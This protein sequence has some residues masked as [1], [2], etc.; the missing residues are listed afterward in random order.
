MTELTRPRVLPGPPAAR[1]AV[2][3]G[4]YAAQGFGYAVVVSALPTLKEKIGFSEGLL[5]AVLLGVCLA[6][7]LGSMLADVIAVRWGSRWSLAAGFLIEAVALAV[8]IGSRDIELFVAAVLAYGLGLGVVDAA[9]NMQGA[10]AEA[11]TSQPLFGRLYAAY[12]VA[13]VLGALATSVVQASDLPSLSTIGIAAFLGT[14]VACLAVRFSDPHIAP[15]QTSGSTRKVVREKLPRRGIFLTGTLVFIAFVVDAAVSSWSTLYMQDGL[16][17]SPSVAPLAYAAY[18]SVV[19]VGR[20]AADPMVKR[21]GRE[22]TS[23]TGVVLALLGCVLLVVVHSPT[24]AIIGFALTGGAAGLLVPVAFSWAG[25]LLPRRSDEVIARVNLF[26]YGGAIVGAAALGALA[27]NAA[28]LGIGFLLP[29][30]ALVLSLPVL[31]AIRQ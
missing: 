18:L 31:R 4:T 25:E 17:S 21:W 16:E 9:C 19:L 5:S 14:L 22:L 1:L 29:S 11:T 6:A 28:D 8:L 3:L 27:G 12:T 7:G 30:I 20:L 26:N 23:L 24:P 10:L 2:T 13:A 15:K